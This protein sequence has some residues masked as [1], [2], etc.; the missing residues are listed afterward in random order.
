[1]PNRSAIGAIYVE[2]DGG[3]SFEDDDHNLTYA[4][5]GRL[6]LGEDGL[7]SGF[8]ARTETPGMRGDDHAYSVIA[9][10]NSQQW[11]NNIGYTEVAENFNP[12]VG[13]LR[14][15]DYR[16]GEARLFRIYRPEN[17]WGLHELRPHVSWRR[18]WKN[19]G[20]YESGLIHADNHWEWRSGLEIHTGVNFT[21]E[22]VLEPFE[23][24]DDVFVEPGKYDHE[25][26]QLV[27]QSNQ[28]APLSVSLTTVIGGFFGG[29]RVNLEPTVR[30]RIGETFS[31]ELT[32]SHNDI[33]LPVPGGDFEVNVGRLRLSYSFT[34]NILLQALVQYDDRSDL[35]A[36]NLR[37]SW[38][39]N[40][41]AG[42]YLVYNEID[43][44]TVI[45][46]IEKRR[47]FVLKYSRI[48]D[49]L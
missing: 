3:I 6:G 26:A 28:G 17:L 38:L 5:D 4:V 20:F 47:E 36:T 21:H 7:I 25:E 10:Y 45:G 35:L 1:L 44:E 22:G 29:D 13:F 33:D 37:F 34:P 49:L 11:S 14:R 18:Y 41:N 32:W 27:F 39:Q 43:D 15:R 31:S 48:I 30:Y 46:P 23:I 2:R 8:L 24:I 12:E 19:D 9:Q 42:L 16:K 40:A